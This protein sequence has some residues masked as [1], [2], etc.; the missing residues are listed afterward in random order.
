MRVAFGTAMACALALALP[1]PIAAEPSVR[2]SL[3][4]AI[5]AARENAPRLAQLRALETAAE[6][7][8]R[9]A[10]G[11]RLPSI[12][13]SAGYTRHSDVP[14][15]AIQL[16]GELP[17]TLFPN[18]PDQWRARIG[19]SETL[20]SGG[21]IRHGI[22]AADGDRRAASQDVLAAE[23][24]LTFETSLAYWSLATARETARVLGDSIASFEAHLR[25]AG[26]RRDLGLASTA[27]V[28]AVRVER[29]RAEAAA[30]QAA[31]DEEVARA[32]LVRLVGLGADASIEP[33]EP[34]DPSALAAEDGEAVDG[35]A[36][37]ERRADRAALAARV[38]AAASR[39][40]ALRSGY[41]PTVAATAGYDYGNPNPRFLP[42][43]DSFRGS[44]SLGVG[45]SLNLYEGG[46]TR[47]AVAQAEALADALRAQLDDLERRIR[48]EIVSRIS[49]V[50]TAKA[51][52]K[53]ASAA[54]D[55]AEE[56]R[57]VSADRYAV[58]VA[59]SS[60]LL[61]AETTVLRAALERTASRAR[62]RVAL[63]ALARAVG[64]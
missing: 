63:A 2:L 37:I 14:E 1:R 46:R 3:G 15:T 64:A 35:D 52:L 33:E 49:D 61:D 21:R 60:E 27:E 51:S 55:A 12:D 29:E 44:W 47:A 41:L 45:L 48:L 20:W 43:S 62:L 9:G 50:R 13:L 54:W 36:A 22:A 17:R 31:G 39:A 34:L 57:R 26:N 32:N 59:S 16:P 56:G 11:L 42:P 6:A 28:L 8:A 30:I 18:L 23:A 19:L 38:E 24:D 10:R 53:V 58:G 25:D 5:R 4:E 7:G 40:R